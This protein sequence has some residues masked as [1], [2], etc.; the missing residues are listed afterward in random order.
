MKALIV[1]GVLL[2]AAALAGSVHAADL[3]LS[4]CTFPQAPTVPDGNTATED[5]M[6]E[7][8]GAVKAF[9]AANDQGLACLDAAKQSLG[10]EAMT[11]EQKVQYTIRYNAA[12]DV[13]HQV[14]NG[15]NEAVRAYNAKKPG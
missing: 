15:W 5:Q 8:S 7:A 9:I 1:G 3:D 11:E 10:A 12:V 13:A 6:I 2:G 14:G 4:Q